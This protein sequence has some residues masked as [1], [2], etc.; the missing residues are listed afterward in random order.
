MAMMAN[1]NCGGEQVEKVEKGASGRLN[2]E[3][4][5]ASGTHDRDPGCDRYLLRAFPVLDGDAGGGDLKGEDDGPLREVVPACAH[6]ERRQYE[7][8]ENVRKRMQEGKHR[9][10][11][12]CRGR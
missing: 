9:E 11:C 3:G 8:V 12:P 10:P 1:Q 6:D 4:N 2:S 5:A 7:N